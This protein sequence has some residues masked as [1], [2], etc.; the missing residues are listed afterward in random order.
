MKPRRIGPLARRLLLVGGMAGCVCACVI[1]P[2]GDFAEADAGP[3]SP[4]VIVSAAPPFEFPLMNLEPGDQRR[5]VLTLRDVDVDDTLYVRFYADYGIDGQQGPVGE[6]NAV[7]TGE[8]VRTADCATSTL[9]ATISD[10]EPHMLEAMVADLDFLAE[11][12]PP[13]RALPPTAAYSFRSWMMT[14]TAAQ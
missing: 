8:Q 2:P 12:D 13:F 6:C 14:C 1:P 11:G 7:P 5:L 4:P 3:S 9:C 10:A